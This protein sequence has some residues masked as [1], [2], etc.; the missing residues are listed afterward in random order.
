MVV[1]W[2]LSVVAQ[3]VAN[4]SVLKLHSFPPFRR[5]RERPDF[6]K[7]FRRGKRLYS[8]YYILY[9]RPNNLGHPRIGVITS[10]RN[11]RKA[12]QRNRVKRVA[13]ETFRL[14]QVELKHV[15]M[16]LIAQRKSNDASNE[17]LKKCLE[18]L[19]EKL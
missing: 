8:P 10:K 5:I 9:Y 11:A 7:T 13:R 15:D 17:E 2:L 14:K 3:K 12:V 4:V 19:F 18:T 16:V 1:D 6:Q